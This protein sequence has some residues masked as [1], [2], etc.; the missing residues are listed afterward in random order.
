MKTTATLEGRTQAPFIKKD[1]LALGPVT[2]CI[3]LTGSPK[4][5]LTL[6]FSESC[7]LTAVSRMFGEDLTELND[8]I[9]DAVG[10]MMNM[11]C[12]QVNNSF[13]QSGISRKAAF[14]RVIAGEKH[15]I[16]HGGTGSVLAV[17]IQTE[18]GSFTMEVFFQKA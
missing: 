1:S 13:A 5:S 17:P 8:E 15:V 7:I 9:Q 11:I 2:G 3:R 16:D 4:I 14:D 18:S 10:E 12:G 6:S